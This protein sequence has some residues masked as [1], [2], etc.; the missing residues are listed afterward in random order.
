MRALFAL[1]PGF[2]ARYPVKKVAAFVALAGTGFYL[3]LAGDQ[4]AANRSFLMVAVMLTA[5]LFDR[6]AL[7]MRNL[8]IAALIILLITPHEV[9]GPSFQMSFAATAA[10]I[11]GYAGQLNLAHAGFMA[12]GAYTL[13]ILMAQRDVLGDEVGQMPCVA[14]V[15]HRRDKV[16]A[17]LR[18]QLLILAEQ[19]VGAP[20][21]GLHPG[22]DL[23][24]EFLL[25]YLHIG[26]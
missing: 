23:A 19:G 11:A 22:C 24:G 20:Q 15:Q 10:L 4:V 6:A 1:F 8:A 3:L 12:I 7:S 26:L 17:E 9:M 5:I 18:H 2:S 25:Q 21:H 16:V 13:A 14:A